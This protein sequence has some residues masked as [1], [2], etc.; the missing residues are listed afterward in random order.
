MSESAKTG[1]YVGIASLVLLWAYMVRPKPIESAEQAETG[2]F[3]I[4]FKPQEC[5]SLEIL[6][7]DE[8]TAKSQQFK[9]EA[10]DGGKF[11]IP[12]HENYPADAKDHLATA[13][14]SV[15]DLEKL[16]KASDSKAT[17]E[18]YGVVDPDTAKLQS[19]AKGVGKRV[20]LEDKAGK[21]LAQFIIGKPVKGQESLRY[22]RT[23]ESDAVFRVKVAVDK[24]S[25]KFEDWIEKDLLKLS[26]WDIKRVILNNY[27]IDE[28]AFP[29]LRKIDGEGLELNYEETGSKWAL[30]GLKPGEELDNEK[31]N[32]LKTALGDLKIVDVRRKPTALAN[33]LKGEGDQLSPQDAQS[34]ESKGFY[35]TQQGLFSNE[36]EVLCQMKDGIQYTLRFGTIAANTGSID[37]K[38]E[39]AENAD[40]DKDPSTPE[41]PKGN[42]RYIF[43]TVAFNPDAIAKPD[44][45]PLPEDPAATEPAKP[46]EPAKPSEES[47]KPADDAAKKPAAGE[48]KPESGD[49]CQ[50]KPDATAT[51]DNKPADAKPADAK[52]ADTKPGEDPAEPE[53]K[54]E[55]AKKRK[56]IETQRK[57]LEDEYNEKIKKG[58]DREKEL[59]ERFAAWYYVISDDVYRKIHLTRAEMIKLT[60]NP[61]EDVTPDALNKIKEEGLKPQPPSGLPEFPQK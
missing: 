21:K 4:I 20:T 29:R 38:E 9:V 22:V 42:N 47:K 59:N 58:G 15:M 18:E 34:L 37:D 25:T 31:L 40:A 61:N 19:G 17:H 32:T 5:A 28:S 48:A 45:P 2:R 41:K 52:P 53:S 3:F 56:E 8:E 11:A 57:R 12:S 39:K 23:P 35:L 60:K 1:L 36:G 44:L 46:E 50:E 10:K 49:N 54:R 30:A 27:S 33:A 24:L 13:A 55:L 7:Y 26:T 43:V 16:G 14:T 51:P 6:A